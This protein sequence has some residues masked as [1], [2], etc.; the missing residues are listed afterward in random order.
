MNTVYENL[1]ENEVRKTDAVAQNNQFGFEFEPCHA[2]EGESSTSSYGDNGKDYIT[3]AQWH[4]D[5]GLVS[6]SNIT[7]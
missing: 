7:V 4:F 6:F 2:P 1:S 3:E 5:K